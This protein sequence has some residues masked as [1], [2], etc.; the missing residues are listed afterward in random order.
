MLRHQAMLKEVVEEAPQ[1]LTDFMVA[2]QTGGATQITTEATRKTAL[3]LAKLQSLCLGHALVLWHVL[4]L[5]VP[6]LT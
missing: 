6:A 2:L 5:R 4:V 3:L 1:S